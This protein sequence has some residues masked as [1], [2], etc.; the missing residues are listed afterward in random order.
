MAPT[1]SNPCL[2]RR[3]KR[4]F[5]RLREVLTGEDQQPKLALLSLPD[6][7]AILEILGDTTL[8]FRFQ[9]AGFMDTFHVLRAVN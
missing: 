6:R 1:F 4:I 5:C 8:N 7:R 3:V 9:H 2:P